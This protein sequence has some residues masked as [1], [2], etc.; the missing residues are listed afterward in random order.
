M[1]SEKKEDNRKARRKELN[2]K[3]PPKPE[4]VPSNKERRHMRNPSNLDRPKRNQ[5]ELANYWEFRRNSIVPHIPNVEGT[6]ERLHFE[7]NPV[8][9]RR[10]A[11]RLAHKEERAEVVGEMWERANNIDRTVRRRS[12]PLARAS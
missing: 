8:Q 12:P 11:K 3:K 2:D 4:G 1:P 5:R 9:R 7:E 10:L 6:R